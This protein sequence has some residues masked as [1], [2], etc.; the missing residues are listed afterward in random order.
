MS[1]YF[2]KLYYRNI[3]QEEDINQHVLIDDLILCSGWLADEAIE[4]KT[5]LLILKSNGKENL[6]WKINNVY[7]KKV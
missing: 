5:A 4:W 1:K 3:D 7:L 2:N 6:F